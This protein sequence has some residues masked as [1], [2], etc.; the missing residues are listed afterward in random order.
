M[1]ATELGLP[2]WWL[3]EQASACVSPAGDNEAPLAFDHPRL[4][5]HAASPPHRLAMKVMASRRRD[6][7]DIR[8][9]ADRIGLTSPDEVLDACAEVFPDEPPP[10]RARAVVEEALTPG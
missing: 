9:L 2:S 1:V 8:L 10:A 6:V 5:V 7:P 4:R 3:N